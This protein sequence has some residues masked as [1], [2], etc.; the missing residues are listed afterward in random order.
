MPARRRKHGPAFKAKVALAVLRDG[1]TVAELAAHFESYLHQITLG[2]MRSRRRRRCRAFGNASMLLR[3]I[4]I[5]LVRETAVRAAQGSLVSVSDVALLKRLKHCQ[6]W[7][8]W[9][10]DGLMQQWL[11]SLVPRLWGDG[12]GCGWWTAASSL[13]PGPP[14][15]PGVCTIR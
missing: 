9:M 2:K 4:L 10:A 15:R 5:H 14:A 7:F 1:A 13:S 8:R 11:T 3:V 6:E 12:G